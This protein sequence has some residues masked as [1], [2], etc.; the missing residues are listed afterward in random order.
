[1]TLA[2]KEF[3]NQVRIAAER[4]AEQ[5]RENKAIQ[6]KRELGYST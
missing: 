4:D 3:L 6:D 1:M 5:A 2:R